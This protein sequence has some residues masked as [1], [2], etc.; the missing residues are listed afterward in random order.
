[1]G[2]TASN[3]SSPGSPTRSDVSGASKSPKRCSP[4]R[5][6]KLLSPSPSPKRGVDKQR[7]VDELKQNGLC[8]PEGELDNA[9]K[10]NDN[11]VE[12][13]SYLISNGIAR[14]L[15]K[16]QDPRTATAKKRPQE[17]VRPPLP[18]ARPTA[19]SRK[20]SQKR[21][22]T[23]AAGEGGEQ[24]TEILSGA[25][26]AAPGGSPRGERPLKRPTPTRGFASFIGGGGFGGLG[27]GGNGGGGGIG[28]DK[29]GSGAVAH[30]APGRLGLGSS[31]R[32]GKKGGGV[33]EDGDNE[34][35][36]SEERSESTARDMD[37]DSQHVL[38]PMQQ[39][40]PPRHR[41]GRS[42]A[43]AALTAQGSER[44]PSRAFTSEGSP[45]RGFAAVR[46]DLTKKKIEETVMAGL[47]QWGEKSEDQKEETARVVIKGLH[48]IPLGPERGQR[49]NED[50]VRCVAAAMEELAELPNVQSGAHLISLKIHDTRNIIHEV[51]STAVREYK[52][53][54][55]NGN[56]PRD[57]TRTDNNRS[58]RAI[59]SDDE[60]LARDGSPLPRDRS[61]GAP[62]PASAP[63]KQAQRSNRF[64]TQSPIQPGRPQQQRPP[65]TAKTPADRGFS[66]LAFGLGGGGGASSFWGN[67]RDKTS[68]G[69]GG[70]GSGGGDGGGNLFWGTP[71]SGDGGGG[72]DGGGSDSGRSRVSRADSSP[73]PSGAGRSTAEQ[74]PMSNEERG[75]WQSLDLCYT[76]LDNAAFVRKEEDWL[77]D[78]LE[79]VR[80]RKR[81]VED[82]DSLAL[83][84]HQNE[85]KTAEGV[86]KQTEQHVEAATRAIVAEHVGAETKDQALRSLI[87][88][89]QTAC[90]QL[91]GYELLGNRGR[92]KLTE[93]SA[94]ASLKTKR[95]RLV[96]VMHATA[97]SAA[98]CEHM[99]GDLLEIAEEMLKKA[100]EKRLNK[101]Q[102]LKSN[103]SA[104]LDHLTRAMGF[105]M[106]RR[107]SAD[108][109]V[110]QSAEKFEH[111]AKFFGED[112]KKAQKSKAT[113]DD[114]QAYVNDSIRKTND[115][116]K[117][118][119]LLVSRMGP[120]LPEEDCCALT[121]DAQQRFAVKKA[122]VRKEAH[123]RNID[124]GGP[125][126]MLQSAE[127]AFSPTSS[128]KG[129]P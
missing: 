120:E 96:H 94:K 100:R 9:L 70:G 74:Q 127:D 121:K 111:N 117:K 15:V 60:R 28:E 92:A 27:L 108:E 122:E 105:H 104:V 84:E 61:Y 31:K 65:V 89:V 64:D 1:M 77:Q 47:A 30:K 116:I 58:N 24:S 99:F 54:M 81:D 3:A 79:V 75:F 118:I 110:R 36:E 97:I 29:S 53:L 25:V 50:L 26:P 6:S 69:G 51:Y 90:G 80:E 49:M 126:S 38:L 82:E 32:D 98:L 107:M 7:V 71:R 45:A 86:V 91:E 37:T 113:L 67:S 72:G 39:G 115:I 5:I 85:V 119:Q 19:S 10:K 43:V 114:M 109:D 125:M 124:V 95:T 52:A 68:G 93:G 42:R 73:S 103:A 16:G 46:S 35:T 44:K 33:E 20:I 21:S 87:D 2:N 101:Q 34:S 112:S 78:Q 129:R 17:N 128:R 88:R 102:V 14:K 106:T 18:P 55:N 8:V 4:K 41:L 48:L 57:G 13:V 56:N 40:S 23:T 62:S 11:F 66:T 12:A 83:E 63:G 22:R 76:A 59:T 123:G